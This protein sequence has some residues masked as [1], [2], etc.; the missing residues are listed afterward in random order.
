MVAIGLGLAACVVAPTDPLSEAPWS[1]EV[2]P[3]PGASGVPRRPVITVQL[4]RRVLPQGVG[5]GV[6]LAS[7]GTRPA[8]SV[9]YD[10]L[11]RAL[12]LQPLYPLLSQTA[13][14]VQVEGLEDLEGR[15]QPKPYVVAFATGD[16]AERGAGLPVASW[17]DIEPLL[18]ERC[19]VDGCHGGS[20]PAAGLDLGSPGGVEDTAIGVVSRRSRAGTLGPEVPRGVGTLAG[21]PLVDRVAGRGRVGS[22]YLLYKV[23]GDPHVLGQAMP[24]QGP[25]L[26]PSEVALVRDWIRGGAPTE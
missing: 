5:N 2:E 10:P 7:G 13:Y 1:F 20:D 11:D 17:Q 12:H 26:D 25:S 4:D 24:P 18:L 8:V 15:R 6:W 23:L 14:S 9:E 19:A 21:L 3:A 16:D 22:S